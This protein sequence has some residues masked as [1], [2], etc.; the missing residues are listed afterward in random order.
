MNKSAFYSFKFNEWVIEIESIYDQLALITARSS[1]QSELDLFGT[2]IS[3]LFEGH[4][5]RRR[6]PNQSGGRPKIL[7]AGS[8]RAHHE[9]SAC[10]EAQLVGTGG[11]LPFL[12]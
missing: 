9:I 11:K 8:H 4:K 2:T 10:S 6:S 1:F 12:Y 5:R 3:S 7:P